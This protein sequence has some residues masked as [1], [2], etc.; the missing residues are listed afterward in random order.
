MAPV[1]EKL[2]EEVSTLNESLSDALAQL[3]TLQSTIPSQVHSQLTQTFQENLDTI[4]SQTPPASSSSSSSSAPVDVP[5]AEDIKRL[6]RVREEIGEQV[7]HLYD[8]IPQT[9]KAIT[10]LITY[11][12]VRLCA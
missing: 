7:S 8:N 6:K 3:E 1:D 11:V 9:I 2:K 5:N 4:T 10:N 12:Q